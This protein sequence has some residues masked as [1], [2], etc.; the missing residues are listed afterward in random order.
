MKYPLAIVKQL[1]DEF[2]YDI[3]L[4]YDIM[5]AFWNT[6]SKS[7]LG[8]ETIAFRLKGVVPAFHGHAHN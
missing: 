8:A 5:C 1:Y 4:A 7:S 2:G 3:C 6:L